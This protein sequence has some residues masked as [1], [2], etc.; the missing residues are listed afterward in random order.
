VVVIIKIYQKI[1]GGL[2]MKKKPYMYYSG[3]TDNTG[4]ALAAKLGGT[5]GKTKPTGADKICICW[6]CKTDKAVSM[7][8]MPVL[9]HPNKI[10]AN[11]HKFNTLQTLTRAGVYVGSHT[12]AKSIMSMLD[13][14]TGD[15]P[16][17]LPVIGRKNYHQGGKDFHICLSKGHVKKAIEA[18]AMYFRNHLDIANEYRLHVFQGV[19]INAQRKTERKNLKEA[20]TE[21]HAERIANN[22]AK[23]NVKLDDATMKHVLGDIGGRQGHANQI[24]KSNTKGWKFSQIKLTNVKEPL[25]EAAIA[26][27]EAVGLDFAAV[28]CVMLEDGRPAIIEL[29]TGPGLEGS[30]FSAYVG[31]FQEA[32][33]AINNPKKASPA[34]TTLK[35]SS[36]KVKAATKQGKTSAEKLRLMADMLDAAET[37]AEKEVLNTTFSKMFG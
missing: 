24:I 9:N 23:K 7:G 4:K 12:D 1:K 36:S 33:K 17:T 2:G 26:A 14:P 16:M 8:S 18:G 21:Q 31:A 3:P 27:V 6:G 19:V 11:R 5:H 32:I 34:P 30:S 10:R 29:N 13:N 22:A 25:K 28:D 35:T 15:E 20:F 37:E